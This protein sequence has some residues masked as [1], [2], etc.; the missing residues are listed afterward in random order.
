MTNATLLSL[1]TARAIRMTRDELLGPGAVP[2]LLAR[3]GGDKGISRAEANL[4]VMA[5]R[6]EL[7]L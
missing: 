5:R 4:V 6:R 2:T 7:G 3:F 1:A